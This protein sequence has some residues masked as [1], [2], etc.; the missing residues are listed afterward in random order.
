MRHLLA[1]LAALA[2]ALHGAAAAH[3]FWMD[4]DQW[5]V[6][7]PSGEVDVRFKVG[8]AADS[9]NWTPETERTLELSTSGPHGAHDRTAS[10]VSAQGKMLAALTLEGEGLHLIALKTDNA[11]NALD[12]DRFNAY[13]IEEGLTPATEARKRA[14]QTTAPGRELYSRRAKALVRVGDASGAPAPNA[15]GQTL[16]IVPLD[17]P[18]ALADDEPLRIRIDYQGV[19]LPGAT[20]KIESLSIGLLPEVAKKTDEH[21]VA[22]FRFPRKSAWKIT[23][24]WTRAIDDPRAD[25][26]TVFSSLTFGYD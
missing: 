17:N 1:T 13:L 24:V 12:A 19:P 26:E 7:A 25:F 18:F 20:V 4:V 6:P 5:S 11:R 23:A 14:Q 2:A 3:D 10:L 8:H 15:V 9:L 21:G 22:S 16:E